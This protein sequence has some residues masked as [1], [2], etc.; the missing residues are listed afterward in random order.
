MQ[1]SLN[2]A[3]KFREISNQIC[4]KKYFMPHNKIIMKEF[5]KVVQGVGRQIYMKNEE[6]LLIR[7]PVK[8]TNEYK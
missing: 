3:I 4:I 8:I 2:L 7:S 5:L 1:V 6:E